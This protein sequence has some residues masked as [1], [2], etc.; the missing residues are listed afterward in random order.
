MGSRVGPEMAEFCIII[1]L[2][3][4]HLEVTVLNIRHYICR[5]SSID[6][7][8]SPLVSIEEAEKYCRWKGDIDGKRNNRSWFHV[9]SCV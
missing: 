2:I 7:I 5:W 4:S 1:W 3:M 6:Q 8:V 9:A